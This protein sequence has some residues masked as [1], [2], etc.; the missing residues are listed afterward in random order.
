LR[1]FQRLIRF[2]TDVAFW[3]LEQSGRG[4]LAMKLEAVEL[5]RV[6]QCFALP[7][8]RW[9]GVMAGMSVASGAYLLL[10]LVGACAGL[11]VLSTEGGAQMDL[12]GAALLWNL[13]GALAASIFGGA[14]A[15]RAADLRRYVDG[16]VHGLVVWG[17]SVLVAALLVLAGVHEAASGMAVLMAQQSTG[18]NFLERT[19][20]DS[21]ASR[22]T[23]ILRASFDR[24]A[25][26]MDGVADSPSNDYAYGARKLPTASAGRTGPLAASIY[27]P[28]MICAAVAMSLCGCIAGGVLG[29]REPRRP[30]PLDHDNWREVIDI[31][32]R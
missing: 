23:G 1:I 25:A 31:L 22:G 12:Q 9:G 13:C 4:V 15:A 27:L 21:P 20:R 24:P 18:Q 5:K 8:V 19:N 26:M 2:G 17:V 11:A 30:D 7:G 28:L 6:S 29:T 14:L 10:M 32:D 16:V 3:G